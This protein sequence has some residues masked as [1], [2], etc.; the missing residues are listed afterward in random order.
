[1]IGLVSVWLLVSVCYVHAAAN[2]DSSSVSDGRDQ[3]EPTLEFGEDVNISGMLKMLKFPDKHSKLARMMYDVRRGRLMPRDFFKQMAG[4]GANKDDLIEVKKQLE[5]NAV[6]SGNK[7]LMNTILGA[8]FAEGGT[9]VEKI[10]YSW[11]RTLTTDAINETIKQFVD[12]GRIPKHGFGMMISHVGKWATQAEKAMT[13]SGDIDFSFVCNDT[14]LAQA[15]KAQFETIMRKQ[16]GLSTIA[17]DAVATVHGRAGLEVYIGRHG[18]QFAEMQMKDNFYV[19]MTTGEQKKIGPEAMTGRLAYERA[20]ADIQ[21]IEV[22]R[23]AFTSEP[24][25]SMEMVRHFD[26]DI[27]KT[28]VYGTLDSVLKAAKYLHRSNEALANTKQKPTDASLATLAFVAHDLD[29]FDPQTKEI[30]DLLLKAIGEH[31]GVEPKV[32]WDA[33]QQRLVLDLDPGT[34]AKFHEQVKDAMWDNVQKGMNARYNDISK[35]QADLLAKKRNGENVIVEAE[36][37]RKELVELLDMVEAELDAFGD[38]KVPDLLRQKAVQVKTLIEQLARETGVRKLNLEELKDKK[39]VEEMLKS[40]TPQSRKMVAAYV[41]DRAVAAAEYT[42][43][44]GEQVNNILDFIDDGL[45]GEL[46]GETGFAALEADINDLKMAR[47]QGKAPKDIGNR[48]TAMKNQVKGAIANTNRVLNES[49]QATAAGRQGMKLVMI[50]GLVDEMKSYGN[51]LWEGDWGGFAAE[52]LRRRVPFVS[53]AEK[54]YMGNT[55][56]AVWDV[57]TTLVPPLAL[58]EAAWGIGREIGNKSYGMYWSEQLALFSDALYADAVFELID[59]E[60]H[61]QGDQTSKLGVYRLQTTYYKKLRLDLAGFAAMRKEQVE[62]LRQTVNKGHLDWQA[63]KKKFKGFTEWIDVSDTLRNNLTAIDPALIL[64]EEMINHTAVGDKFRERMAELGLARWE[65]IKLGYILN[66]ID[67]LEKRKQAEDALARGQLPDLFAE[68]RRVVK[69]LDIEEAV[70]KSLDAEADTSNYKAL[71]GVLWQAKRDISDQP[72]SESE[73]SRASQVVLRYLDVYKQVTAIQAAGVNRLPQTH[74]NDGSQKWLTGKVFFRGQPDA[75]FEAAKKW[76]Q[77][78]DQSRI[79]VMKAMLEIKHQFLPNSKLE[80]KEELMMVDLAWRHELWMKPFNQAGQTARSDAW[81]DRSIAHGKKRN[82]IYD[83]YKASLEKDA[84]VQLTLIL[85]DAK[86]PKT[87]IKTARAEAVPTD[88]LGKPAVTIGSD[89]LI[90]NLVKGRY[91]ISIQARGYLEHI[92]NET[93]GSN[94]DKTPKR[95]I[96]LKPSGE[97]TQADE[98]PDKDDK[99]ESDDKSKDKP[100]IISMA[101]DPK[102]GAAIADLYHSRDWQGLLDL[103]AVEKTKRLSY[104][105]PNVYLER[106]GAI[107]NALQGLKTERL[108]WLVK[109]KAYL[110]ALERIGDSKWSKIYNEMEFKRDRFQSDCNARCKDCRDKCSEQA[111]KYYDDCVGQLKKDHWAE[112][113]RIRASIKELPEQVEKLD[114]GAYSYADWF[115]QVEALSKKHR[116]P[117][118]YP[119]PVVPQLAY[120]TKCIDSVPEDKVVDKAQDIDP[121]AVAVPPEPVKVTINGLKNQVFYGSTARLNAWG[122]GLADTS[123]LQAQ[124]AKDSGLKTQSSTAD[125]DGWQPLDSNIRTTR[126]ISALPDEEAAPPVNSDYRVIWQAEPGLSFSPLDSPDGVTTVTYD[127]MGEVKIWCELHKQ[128]NGVFQTVGESEQ[129]TIMVTAP[130][131]SI[132]FEPTDGQARVGQEVRATIVASPGIP[133]DLVG[134]RW[135]DPPSS[136]RFEIDKNAG[137]ISFMIQDTRPVKLK[138]LARIPVHGDEIRTVEAVYTGIAYTVKAWMVQPPNLPMTWDPKAGGLKTIPAGQRTTDERITLTAEVQGSG[139]PDN[140][141][142]KWT[143]NDGTSISNDNSQSPTVSRNEPGTIT[144]QVIA[145]DKNGIKLGTAEMMVSVIRVVSPPG[146]IKGKPLSE[147]GKPSAKDQAKAR[148]WIALARTNLDQGDLSGARKALTKARNY[149]SKAAAPIIREAVTAAKKIGWKA[150][151]DRNFTKAVQDLTVAASLA[152]DDADARDKLEKSQRF[153]AIWPKVEAK[154]KE[155]DQLIAQNKVWSA[156]KAMLQMQDLQFDMPG[157]MANPLSQK[158]MADFDRALKAY[159]VFMQE[160]NVIHQRTFDQKNWQAMLDSAL[161]TQTR[162]LSPADQKEVQSR[163]AFARQQLAARK[164]NK[165]NNQIQHG[166]SLEKISGTWQ[167]NAN[168]F[169][170]NIVIGSSGISFEIGGKED[171]KDIFFDGKTLEFTRPIPCCTQRYTGILKEQ[172]DGSYYLEGTFTQHG[173]NDIFRWHADLVK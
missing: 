37:M 107:G 28:G 66:L 164:A 113:K 168:D 156:H 83:E 98:E 133:S 78:I 94:L 40:K 85:T 120:V 76:D 169:L 112:G 47:R 135:F 117:F 50:T 11:R 131:F 59:V 73:I 173:A 101:N 142:W 33:G 154:V 148:M 80:T 12:Q 96:A 32:I 97:D 62:A 115:R 100:E 132:N 79:A 4:L 65:E 45:L 39:L 134:Y 13:F 110:T 116:L 61:G 60:T 163:I 52:V 58:P 99:K 84:P 128:I 147:P 127:R 93:F 6:R 53:A 141:R 124:P 70:L 95:T 92:Q 153:A 114:S 86:N 140:V 67:H 10:L 118:P 105:D 26:H 36:N 89:Q 146:S 77:Y 56:L 51:A 30:R 144:A 44:K 35:R 119:D 159:N 8:G 19:D 161:D 34:I 152:P 151:Y 38:E 106:T 21:G 88:E 64:L 41:M 167:T 162:E 136:N 82:Q 23:P 46:R 165:Q 108:T 149:D 54:A 20:I 81:L 7:S 166:I 74:Q 91:R 5:Q 126:T 2:S 150:S 63:Y 29:R 17:I 25:L 71:I 139:V 90:L 104:R 138:V 75:D 1:M 3:P 103:L 125:K 9:P 27:V 68:I 130:E 72:A 42:V 137:R 15:M 171:M 121:P 102:L 14:D 170:G 22:P 109:W 122:M 87:K 55:Y 49:L 145:S 172:S 43:K 160:K 18:M 157:Q 69:V 24:G 16:T 158:V 123:S 31:F 57:V 48:L 129:Q 143:V 155:F 111:Y